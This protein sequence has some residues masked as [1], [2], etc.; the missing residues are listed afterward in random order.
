MRSVLSQESGEEWGAVGRI[1]FSGTFFHVINVSEITV[2]TRGTN[3]DSLHV[4][5]DE[6]C[7][8]CKVL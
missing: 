8:V 4:K 7:R 5:R 3:A 2:K 1:V 6:K